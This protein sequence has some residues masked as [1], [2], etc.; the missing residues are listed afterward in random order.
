MP[1]RVVPVYDERPAAIW[2]VTLPPSARVM[3]PECTAAVQTD[4]SSV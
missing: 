3:S 2:M 4:E 1:W